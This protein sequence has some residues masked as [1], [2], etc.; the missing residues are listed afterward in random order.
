GTPYGVP[1]VPAAKQPSTT[2]RPGYL[3]TD[4]MQ[5]PE[6]MTA[7]TMGVQGADRLKTG[8]TLFFTQAG[9]TLLTQHRDTNRTRPILA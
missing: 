2:S 7:T 8:I 3:W 4:A 6:K 9:N 5:H 1:S